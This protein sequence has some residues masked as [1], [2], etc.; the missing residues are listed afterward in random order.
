M[1]TCDRHIHHG[2]WV[3]GNESKED[4]QTQ[5][6]EEMIRRGGMRPGATVLDVG[7]SL[8]LHTHREREERWQ[9]CSHCFDG[10]STLL[11]CGVGGTAI[12]LAKNYRASVTGITL[13]PVQRDMAEKLAQEEGA[14]QNTTFHRM[15]GE[16]M[17]FSDQSYFIE[18]SWLLLH[19]R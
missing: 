10:C 3:N 1:I 14:Q 4:A 5:L 2:Y 7:T 19:L 8:S 16:N 12:Y 18:Q 11:G 6:I 9:T 17:T 13:S 15:D